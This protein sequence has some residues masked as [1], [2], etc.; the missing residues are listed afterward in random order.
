MDEERPGRPTLA[1]LDAVEHARKQHVDPAGTEPAPGER[2]AVAVAA[3]LAVAAAKDER[4][5]PR[6]G[7]IVKHHGRVA[8]DEVVQV[9]TKADQAHTDPPTTT[10]TPTPP[11][12]PAAPSTTLPPE[13]A[14]ASTE[15]PDSTGGSEKCRIIGGRRRGPVRSE[16]PSRSRFSAG[17]FGAQGRN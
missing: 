14:R 17:D 8:A 2:G 3:L 6:P 10:A 11:S 9:P 1:K 12:E 13:P 15:A 16:G 4:D 7:V 5:A